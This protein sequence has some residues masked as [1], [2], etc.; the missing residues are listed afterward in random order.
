MGVTIA[1]GFLIGFLVVSGLGG[2]LYLLMVAQPKLW[3]KISGVGL[4]IMQIAGS[5]VLIN[6][7]D[8]PQSLAWVLAVSIMAS[9]ILLGLTLRIFLKDI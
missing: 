2:G 8:W 9:I 6:R 7:V 1:L 4:I 3:K 5:F